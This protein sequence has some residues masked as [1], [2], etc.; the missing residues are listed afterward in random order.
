MADLTITVGSVSKGTGC[1]VSRG[2]A[3][4]TITQGV[5]VYLDSADN[6]LKPADANVSVALATVVGI[7][8]NAAAAGQSVQIVTAGPLTI[9]ATIV[10]GMPYAV[11]TAAGLICPIT[12]I[13][14][15][16]YL[17]ILGVAD[18]ATVLRVDIIA[19][20]VAIAADIT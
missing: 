10:V 17:C 8:A 19:P 15:G 5:P 3:G 18:S 20:T 16:N 4:A 2:T 13:A 12:D 6:L 1:R 11:S 9:G 14:S 7:A